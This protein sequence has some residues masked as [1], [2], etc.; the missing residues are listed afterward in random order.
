MGLVGHR[1]GGL[2]CKG[3][4]CRLVEAN[5]TESLKRLGGLILMATP[6]AGSLR[7]P[8]MLS[9][10]SYDFQALKPHGS[11][12]TR[13]NST[14]SNHIALDE[15]D[16]SRDKKTLLPTW[17]IL[18]DSDRWVDELSAGLSLPDKRKKMVRG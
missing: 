11:F 1:E 5:D 18:G 9:F 12:V 4:V 2:L 15:G 6:Q 8:K 13:I 3:A 14:F 17:A 16:V 10:L 7:A